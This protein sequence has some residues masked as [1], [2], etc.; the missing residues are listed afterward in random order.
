MF[1]ARL[2]SCPANNVL[3]WVTFALD[4]QRFALPLDSV[5]R[6]VRAAEITPLPLASECVAGALDVGGRILPVI[7]LR[8]RL[9]L[10]ERSLRLSDQ[11][12]IAR[13]PRRNLA[14]VVDSALGLVEAAL[15]SALTTLEGQRAR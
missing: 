11:F 5:L 9:R 1:A 8:R 4:D 10:P 13:T 12:L 2:R 15:D 6:V 3:R 7:D 14:L